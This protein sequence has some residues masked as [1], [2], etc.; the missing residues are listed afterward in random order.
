M[1]RS[2]LIERLVSAHTLLYD[3]PYHYQLVSIGLVKSP[4]LIR[5][6]GQSARFVGMISKVVHLLFQIAE[7]R[8]FGNY[9][10]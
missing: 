1:C 9:P 4:N 3:Y 6:I 8:T 7:I 10:I 2:A 5:Q